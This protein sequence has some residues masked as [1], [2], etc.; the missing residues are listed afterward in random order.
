MLDS[1][2]P[3]SGVKP[4]ALD[5]AVLFKQQG[6]IR[7]LGTAVIAANPQLAATL[8]ANGLTRE[9]AELEQ[10]NPMMSKRAHQVERNLK[11]LK[12]EWEHAH[13]GEESGPVVRARLLH[14]AWAHERPNKKPADL[15]DEHAWRAELVEAG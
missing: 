10:F 12:A 2:C 15:G 14:R 9:V 3:R 8:D 5:T 6:A 1:A 7:A 11:Q 4:R 13:P